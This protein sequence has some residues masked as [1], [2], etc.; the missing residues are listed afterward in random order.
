MKRYLVAG[1][2]FAMALGGREEQASPRAPATPAEAPPD[3]ELVPPTPEPPA[4][5][6]TPTD[7]DPT[8]V[9]AEPADPVAADPVAAPSLPAPRDLPAE[10]RAA[11]GSPADCVRDNRPSYATTI[12]IDIR[13]VVRPTGMIIEPGATG[14]GLSRNDTRCIEERL[15]AVTLKP[16]TG[17]TSET[18][19]T[20]LEI[21][22][23]PPAV[24]A[25]D[26]APPPPPADGVVQALPK[27]KPIAPSGTPIDGPAPDPIEGPS[28]T[29]I[30]GP[31]PVPISGPKPVPIGAN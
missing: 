26:V 27:K 22:Y 9:E 17:E 11:V 19:T 4:A 20:T 13:A 16:L 10:L 25:Y 21:P 31:E 6:R 18:V 7:T 12:R 3:E 23:E 1:A 28:G 5:D 24:E 15:G 2:L 14:R 30:D 29:P 8:A